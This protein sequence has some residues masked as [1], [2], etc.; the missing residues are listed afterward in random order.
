[1][2]QEWQEAGLK[3]PSVIRIH[4]I[5]TLDKSLVELKMGKVS[6]TLKARIKELFAKITE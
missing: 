6:L 5:A 3:L 4:K 1:M 2:I